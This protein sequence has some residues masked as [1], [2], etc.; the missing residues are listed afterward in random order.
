MVSQAQQ[1]SR[2][3]WVHAAGSGWGRERARALPASSASLRGVPSEPQDGTRPS[4]ILL[5]RVTAGKSV[6]LV[7][8]REEGG[9]KLTG[10]CEGNGGMKSKRERWERRATCEGRTGKL[11]HL[12]WDAP[13]VM[14]V[15]ALSWLGT[16]QSW[17]NSLAE[18]DTGEQNRPEAASSCAGKFPLRNGHR[19]S[20]QHNLS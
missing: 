9:R 8:N 10:A 6:F 3:F 13:P 19:T 7:L 17:Q 15:N 4:S 16:S 5:S 12:V 14:P 11:C 18:A 20:R 1:L 2:S